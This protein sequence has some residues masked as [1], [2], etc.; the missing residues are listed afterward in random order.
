M[1]VLNLVRILGLCYRWAAAATEARP[2]RLR[3]CRRRPNYQANNGAVNEMRWLQTWQRQ[4]RFQQL[5]DFIVEG[6]FCL[7]SAVGTMPTT[8]R[9]LSLHAKVG[10]PE[11]ALSAF[12]RIKKLEL[13]NLAYHWADDDEQ[14]HCVFMV[15]CVLDNLCTLHLLDST[16]IICRCAPSCSIVACLPNV[17]TFKARVGCGHEG[18]DIACDIARLPCLQ[19]LCLLLVQPGSVLLGVDLDYC[20]PLRGDFRLVVANTEPF[21][22]LFSNLTE[23]GVSYRRVPKASSKRLLFYASRRD[24]V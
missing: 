23:F 12:Q 16:D 1:S 8:I 17:T 18:E 14:Y 13:L 11:F 6:T 9:S 21:L 22:H 24:P 4:G 20:V 7:F 2:R 19:E 3:I 15:D 5:Q 10:P